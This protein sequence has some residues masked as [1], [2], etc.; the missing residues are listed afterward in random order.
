MAYASLVDVT[1]TQ[2]A[3]RLLVAPGSPSTSYLIDKLKGTNMCAGSRMPKAGPL[4]QAQI[5]LVENWI[6]AGAIDN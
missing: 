2:C 6:T 1:S 3:D 5:N 4:T